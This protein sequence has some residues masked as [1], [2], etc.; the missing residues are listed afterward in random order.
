M[1]IVETVREAA[2]PIVNSL[3]LELWDVEYKKEGS[4][5]YLRVFIDRPEGVWISDCEAVSREL[6]PIIDKLDMI[7]H[8]FNFE[9]YSAGLVRELKKTEHLKRF[10][11]KTVTVCLFKS[12]PELA[13]TN[14]KFTAVLVDAYDDSVDLEIAGAIKKVDR[15]IVSKITIDL[16]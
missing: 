12:V 10:L 5:Y 13:G 1:S 6:D 4:E 15:K 3:G 8:S 14:K 16:V 2:E 9:V 11:G 7:D